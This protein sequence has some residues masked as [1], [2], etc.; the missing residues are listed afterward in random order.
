MHVHT[1]SSSYPG[2][3]RAALVRRSARPLGPL[4]ARFHV[5]GSK[6]AF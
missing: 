5:R 1:F 3:G 2:G 6:A 4:K